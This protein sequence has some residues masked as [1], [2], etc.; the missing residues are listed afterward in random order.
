M[1]C[2]AGAAR[3][4]R[5]PG[6]RHRRDLLGLPGR[7]GRHDVS[8]FAA[9]MR[10]SIG[11]GLFSSLYTDRGSHYFHRRR[12]AARWTRGGRPR[13]AGRLPSSASSTS[14]LIRP[15]RAA[16]WSGCSARS[17]AGCRRNCA[18]PASTTS[19]PPT[20]SSPTFLT[21]ATTPASR[22]RR[23]RR[24]APSFPMSGDLAD[25]LCVQEERTVGKDNCV[26]YKRLC[27]QIPPDRHRHH[28]VKTKVRVHDYPGRPPR[29]LPRPAPARPL[30]PTDPARRGARP[31]QESSAA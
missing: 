27:L 28:Y 7:G 18:S 29:G 15:R 30:R 9:S 31:D 24:A 10:R 6:R 12:P 14:R 19:R 20:A 25:I 3:P 5:H 11:H 16:A 1:A 13:L 8:A 2:R 4:D 23:P 17:R 21:R 26:L 22:C